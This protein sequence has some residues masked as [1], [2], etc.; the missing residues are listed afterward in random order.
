MCIICLILHNNLTRLLLLLPCFYRWVSCSN[1]FCLTKWFWQACYIKLYI[2]CKWNSDW[3]LCQSFALLV[4]FVPN[5]WI[6]ALHAWVSTIYCLC[7]LQDNMDSRLS[8]EQEFGA[9]NLLGKFRSVSFSLISICKC[10]VF[11]GLYLNLR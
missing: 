4:S 1:S 11:L 9:T 6:N 7:P 8:I 3:T 2:C 5:S 10:I